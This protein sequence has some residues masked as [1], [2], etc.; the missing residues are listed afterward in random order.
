MAL[1]FR[2]EVAAPATKISSAKTFTYTA[3]SNIVETIDLELRKEHK[4]ISTLNVRLW[5]PRDGGKMFPIF[6]ALPDPGFADVGVKLYL[7]KAGESQAASKLVFDG[8]LGSLQPGYPGPSHT[9]LVAHDRSL[10]ARLQASY[11]TFKN[12]TSVDLAK[13]ISQAYGMTIDVS[14]LGSLVLSQRLI[15]MGASTV[16]RGAFSDWAHLTR[17]LAVDGLELYVKGKT[18]YVRQTAQITYPTAF[19]PDDETVISFDAQINHVHGPGAGGPSKV[20][21]PAG[22]KGS[23]LSASGSIAQEG[24][25]EG[26]IATTHRVPVQGPKST[27][28]GAHTEGTGDLVGPSVQR[29]RRKD[30]VSLTVRLSPDIDMRHLIQLKGWGQKIDGTWYIESIHHSLVGS[31]A[32]TTALTLTTHPSSGGL[33]QA[34]IA[35]PAGNQ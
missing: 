9:S 26:S 11:K 25:A 33:K 16:G 21:V 7:S 32:G 34:G 3:D 6:N 29:R 18:I 23:N 22:N 13:A 15:D 20:P 14:E 19:T 2:V 4:A 30:T 17:A 10:G 5:D 35:Q 28:T 27:V 8:K 1:Y 31:S 24:I 12:R